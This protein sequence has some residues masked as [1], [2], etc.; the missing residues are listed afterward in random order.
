[1]TDGGLD[2]TFECVGSVEL[3]RSALEA[4]HKGWGQSIIVGASAVSR[5]CVVLCCVVLCCV[6]LC[7]VVLCCVVLCCVVLCCVVL[8]CV[9]REGRR[10]HAR[11]RC[12]LASLRA[13]LC[14]SACMFTAVVS[15]SC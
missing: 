11:S 9:A 13:S 7:C 1:M 5:C 3:M 6:V 8:C 14:S 15:A 2:Y 4:A 10:E 12:S